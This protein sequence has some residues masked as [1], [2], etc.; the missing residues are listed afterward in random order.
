MKRRVVLLHTS[1]VLLERER[2]LLDLLEEFLPEVEISH[3][4]EHNMAFEVIRQGG[5]TPELTRRMCLY[6]LAAESMG[7][8]AIF[9]T[10]SSLGPAIDVARTLVRVPVVKIDEAMAEQAAAA[11]SRIGV[12]ATARSTVRPTSDLVLAKA[13]AIGRLPEVR[14]GLCVGAFETLMQGDV[15][16]HDDM[17]VAK[18]HDLASWA[19]TIVLAQA[20]LARLEPRIGAEIGLPVLSSP[21]SGVE[22]LRQVLED[23]A[24]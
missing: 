23:S 24:R 17:V 4:V 2:L 21:R 11:G 22:R 14:D 18:A 10:C 7:V 13:A 20:T 6:V 9:N 19:D 5:I 1:L 8:D 15:R 3:I 12:L 16:G